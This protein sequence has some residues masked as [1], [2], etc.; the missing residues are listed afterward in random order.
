MDENCILVTDQP[1]ELANY[2]EQGLSAVG[3]VGSHG[4]VMGANGIIPLETA[5]TLRELT[6]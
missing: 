2:L 5:Q 1:R 3:E 4:L 6:E